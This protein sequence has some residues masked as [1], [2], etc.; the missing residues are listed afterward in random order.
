MPF[1]KWQGRV[2]VPN[3]E[4]VGGRR[5]IEERCTK[6]K[7]AVPKNLLR[8]SQK[9]RTARHRSNSC[10]SHRMSYTGSASWQV[11]QAQFFEQVFNI[12][13]RQHVG[14]V[15]ESLFLNPFYPNQQSFFSSERYHGGVNVQG[16]LGLRAAVGIDCCAD[17]A[18]YGP[19][20]HYFQTA[21][22]KSRH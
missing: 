17:D 3:Y 14:N 6:R 1:A 15:S 22:L 16:W 11:R 13:L 20:G 12:L 18:D 10:Q 8:D 2:L 19:G 7:R 9:L 4:P 5:F 21:A